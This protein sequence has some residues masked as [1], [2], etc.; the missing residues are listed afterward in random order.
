[1]DWN[2]HVHEYKINNFIFTITH[3][4]AKAKVDGYFGAGIGPIPLFHKGCY[5]QSTNL[6]S[7]YRESCDIPSC[8]SH[9][10]DVGVICQGI[11]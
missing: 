1:M 6:L 4:G 5:Q 9:N 10:H 7:C 3:T 11:P 2:E 8:T